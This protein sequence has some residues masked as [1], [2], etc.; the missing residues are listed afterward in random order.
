MPNHVLCPSIV[1]LCGELLLYF[2]FSTNQDNESD[3]FVEFGEK[4]VELPEAALTGLLPPPTCDLEAARN[5]SYAIHNLEFGVKYEV[6][7]L[8]A[9]L[10]MIHI[11]SS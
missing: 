6:R 9:M 1:F 7:A 8:I 11:T 4:I 5:Y 3:P 2:C 10:P